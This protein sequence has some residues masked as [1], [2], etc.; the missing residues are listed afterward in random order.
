MCLDVDLELTGLCKAAV[1]R[2]TDIRPLPGVY[3]YVL[4]EVARV[5][6]HLLAELALERPVVG[7]DPHMAA[8]LTRMRELPTAV[9]ARERFCLRLL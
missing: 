9:L 2:A 3:S 7:V 1:A 4:G 8:Q 5:R 6:E